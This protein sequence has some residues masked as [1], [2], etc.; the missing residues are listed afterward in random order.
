MLNIDT[1]CFWMKFEEWIVSRGSRDLT[2][3]PAATFW[4]TELEIRSADD[5]AWAAFPPVPCNGA[6]EGGGECVYVCVHVFAEGGWGVTDHDWL[7][8]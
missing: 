4:L 8:W 2:N 3:P 6:S 1:F 5:P 7:R